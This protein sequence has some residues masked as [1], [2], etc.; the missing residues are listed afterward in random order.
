MR[1][2]TLALLLLASGC[3]GPAPEPLDPA[4]TESDFR[5]RRLDDPDLLSWM[6]SQ[7]TPK[8]EVW[9]LDALTL[10]AFYYHPDL[11][12]ARA[13]LRGAEGAETTAGAIPN[14]TLNGDLEKVLGSTVPGVSPWV[15]GFNLQMPL[16]F[17]WKRGYRVD[18]A[19][20]RTQGA[21]LELG[22]AAWAVRHRL[23]AALLEDLLVGREVELRSR[24]A[25]LRA[26]AAATAQRLFSTG[27]A[28]R[29]EADRARA[30]QMGADLQLQDA[31]G[32][33]AAARAALASAVGVPT[34]ALDGIRLQW[35]T[36][37]TP[38]DESQWTPAALQEA[39]LLNRL[40]V[41]R[42][43]AEYAAAEAALGLEVAKQMPD[44]A[45]GPG[46]LFDQGDRKFTIGFSLTLPIFNQNSG[47]IAEAEAKR[48]EVAAQFLA[49]QARAIGEFDGATARLRAAQAQRTLAAQL[50][51]ASAK[52]VTDLRRAMDLGDADRS[53]WIGA[54]L[55]ASVADAAALEA[56]RRVQEAL[57]A[58]EDAVQRPLEGR[59]P[60]FNRPGKP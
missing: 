29:L 58:L 35:P 24:D 14:P 48:R 6:Q 33:V 42:G 39:G 2:G 36:L 4:R 46:Y 7:G 16:D 21:S 10:A 49:L 17:L 57:G 34:A 41:R 45:L 55:E 23:R 59:L 30:E 9:T 51:A 20:A 40:D 50:Q 52:R 25:A 60:S 56:L 43:L 47:P 13:R 28:S 8:P 26:E 37:D 11:D 15:W 27:E 38:P 22:E 3:S 19:R 1:R 18:E 54:R 53:A 32:K 44:L 31:R 12:V 5:A